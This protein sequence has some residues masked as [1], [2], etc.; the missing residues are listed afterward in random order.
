M[1]IADLFAEIGFK[2]D[3]MKLKEVGKAIADLNISSIISTG[4]VGL[5]GDKIADLITQTSEMAKGLQTITATTG[6]GPQFTQQFEN[7][8]QALGSSKQEADSF[9]VSLSKLQTKIAMGQ[10]GTDLQSFILGG[11]SLD[12]I[13]GTTEDLA[14]D[15]NRVLS[16]P[17]QPG[18]Q[19]SMERRKRLMAMIGEGFQASPS[20]VKALNDPEMFTKMLEFET[21]SAEQIQK[22]VDANYNWVKVTNDLNISFARLANDLSP[23]LIAMTKLADQGVRWADAMGRT[24]G[25][26]D[27]FAKVLNVPEN[28]GKVFDEVKRLYSLPGPNIWGRFSERDKET[29]ER[30]NNHISISVNTNNP[31]EFGRKLKI[32]LDKHANSNMAKSDLQFIQ[33][34]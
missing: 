34:T 17:I 8:S 7:V 26:F 15:I 3:T 29:I 33:T 24:S 22:S 21:L 13:K 12:K 28:V 16:T 20:M 1:K 27:N 2:F 23:I 30:S 14:K 9:L 32:F 18:D 19:A 4:A 10:G 6:I 5:L 31:E 25:F 11:I